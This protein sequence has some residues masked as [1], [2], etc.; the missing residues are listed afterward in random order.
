MFEVQTELRQAYL[1]KL[2]TIEISGTVIPFYDERVGAD[3][4]Q[5]GTAIAYGIITNQ[6]ASDIL[7]KCGFYQDCSITIDIVTKF[8]KQKGGKLLSEQISNEVLQLLRTGNT[9][10]Y[11]VMDNFQIVTVRKTLDRGLT[12]DNVADTVYRKILIFTHK[13]KQISTTT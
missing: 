7:I 10:D 4:A 2:S 9:L 11:P 5:I 8:P 12:E 13:I 6:T 3:P 1:A